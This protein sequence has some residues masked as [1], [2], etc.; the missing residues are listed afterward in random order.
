MRPSIELPMGL[1]PEYK[2]F[3]F[4]PR[5][6]PI[7]MLYQNMLYYIDYTIYILFISYLSEDYGHWA[8]LKIKYTKYRS[9]KMYK[10]MRIDG[11][12]REHCYKLRHYK[13]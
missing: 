4:N 10:V 12:V 11:Q 13:C 6:E 8:N 9:I 5:R 1:L 7:D 2:A 3:F